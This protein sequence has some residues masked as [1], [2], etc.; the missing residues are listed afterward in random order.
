MKAN[1]RRCRLRRAAG[2]P[3]ARR[4]FRLALDFGPL[5]GILLVLAS[6]SSAGTTATASSASSVK[7]AATVAPTL[8]LLPAAVAPTSTE[9]ARPSSSTSLAGPSF[10]VRSVATTERTVSSESVRPTPE[11]AS[12][13]ATTVAVATTTATSSAGGSATGAS[14]T[15]WLTYGR[16]LAR[17]GDDPASGPSQSAKQL[18][19]SP[20]LDGDIYG[21][22]LLDSGRLFIVTENNT[23]YSLDATSGKVVWQQHVGTPISRSSLP[24]GDIDPTGITGTPVIDPSSGTLFAVAFEQPGKH[25]LYAVDVAT[26]AVQYHVPIDPPGA[27]P[28]VQQQ[29]SALALANGMVY[30]A[31]GGLDGDC[32]QYHGWVVAAAATNGAIGAT[33]Q[34]PTQREG[35]IW[36]PAGPAIDGAGNL[37]VATGNGSSTSQFDYGNSVMKLSP[38]LK[39]LDWFAPTNWAELNR[40]D[41]DIGSISPLLVPNGLIF[42]IGKSGEG[43]LLHADH[44]GQIGGQAFAAPVCAGGYGAFGSTAFAASY[45]Y[46]PCRNGMVALHLGAASFSTAWTG[47]ASAPDSP[48]VAGGV[49]W[50]VN[51]AQNALVG[52]DATTGASRFQ[53]ALPASTGSLPHFIAP[54]VA[55]NTVYV[56]VGR[57]VL[58]VR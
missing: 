41:L 2:A 1:A 13:T 50:A 32:G 35:A 53:V 43:Y 28:L 4:L 20:Q 15:N 24:C 40:T 36:A 12:S 14:A 27:D 18:W 34:V 37:F 46:V 58:A 21:E 11:A 44:L 33:Y 29:R 19:Q 23:F 57:V 17:T 39:V 49:V 26:G 38:N 45:I 47:P 54:M 3:P 31:Y 9:A 56:A 52:L 22:P 8:P 25:E 30:V 5:L 10:T 42:Q 6:C 16:I 48:V 51:P 55:T 7:S